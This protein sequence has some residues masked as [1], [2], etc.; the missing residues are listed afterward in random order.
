MSKIFSLDSSDP[1]AVIVGHRDLNPQ[2]ACPC[3]N[4]VSEYRDLQP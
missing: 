1:L 3:F 4:A 2:K